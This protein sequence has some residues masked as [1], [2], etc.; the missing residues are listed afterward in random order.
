MWKLLQRP[1]WRETHQ[2]YINQLPRTQMLM[3]NAHL[4]GFTNLE[5]AE[6]F[7]C[8]RN[9]V[10]NLLRAAE[11]QLREWTGSAM[12]F[13][14]HDELTP[15]E[16]TDLSQVEI[17]RKPPGKMSLWKR[18]LPPDRKFRLSPTSRRAA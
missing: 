16:F 10:C 2:G 14:N 15:R 5:I 8:H 6:T 3:V 7:G 13:D 9:T 18:Q 1:N 11:R 4:D 12:V 17:Y